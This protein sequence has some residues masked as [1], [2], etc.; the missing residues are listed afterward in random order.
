MQTKTDELK[1]QLAAMRRDLMRTNRIMSIYAERQ[2]R[3]VRIES[4]KMLLKLRHESKRFTQQM[5]DEMESN[6][7]DYSERV[8]D[9][10]TDAL[11]GEHGVCEGELIEEAKPVLARWCEEAILPQLRAEGRQLMQKFRDDLFGTA[12]P[13]SSSSCTACSS[14]KENAAPPKPPQSNAL[15]RFPNQSI[16]F[17]GSKRRPYPSAE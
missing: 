11:G 7:E 16:I 12:S 14:S 10:V 5:I 9:T 13:P 17:P 4:Q 6:Y 1:R 3:L 15:R 2:K 8:F